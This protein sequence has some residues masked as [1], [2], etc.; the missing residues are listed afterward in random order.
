[1]QANETAG[2]AGLTHAP[3]GPLS[4]SDTANQCEK[5]GVGAHKKMSAVLKMDTH[6][7]APSTN[8]HPN[9]K[10][11]YRTNGLEST[12]VFPVPSGF[13]SFSFSSIHTSSMHPSVSHT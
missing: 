7:N 12:E 5:F 10:D 11:S 1:M 8:A 13:F 4:Y 2:Q 9:T 6:G 3:S